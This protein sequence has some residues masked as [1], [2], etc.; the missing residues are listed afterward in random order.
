[1]DEP[2]AAPVTELQWEEPTA[3]R[4]WSVPAIT[5]HTVDFSG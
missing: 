1:M 2:E 4:A 5:A 3:L